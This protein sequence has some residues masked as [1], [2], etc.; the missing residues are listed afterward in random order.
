MSSDLNGRIVQC[1]LQHIAENQGQV[2]E[3]D[4]DILS[5]LTNDW[6]L[7]QHANDLV[8]KKMVTQVQAEPSGRSFFRVKSATS[9]APYLV[10]PHYCSC[11]SF[12][13]TVSKTTTFGY[14]KHSLAV[15][16]A[17][18]LGQY[19]QVQIPDAEFAVKLRMYT[20]SF[21]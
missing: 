14:C 7:L 2:S 17:R 21:S 9:H 15:A 1:V 11:L 6:E 20:N 12:L 19:E 18:A 10:Y 4:A 5:T 3:K 13:H 16:L 8:E